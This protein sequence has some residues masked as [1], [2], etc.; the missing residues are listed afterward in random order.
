MDNLNWQTSLADTIIMIIKNNQE[1]YHEI[2]ELRSVLIYELI[3]RG[4]NINDISHWVYS[5]V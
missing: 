2:S 3:S 5:I 1:K 4:Y